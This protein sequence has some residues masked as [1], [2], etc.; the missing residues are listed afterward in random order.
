[1]ILESKT[2][3][4]RAQYESGDYSCKEL[5]E[6]EYT[7]GH[8]AAAA[9]TGYC[10]GHIRTLNSKKLLPSPEDYMQNIPIWKTSKLI[11]WAENK[12]R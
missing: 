2:V 5:K 9:L 12:T 6:Q 4:S 11:Q 8:Y 7:A 1:M 10:V 3:L